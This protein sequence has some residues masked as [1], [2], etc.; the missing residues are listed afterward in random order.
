MLLLAEDYSR[1]QDQQVDSSKCSMCLPV[2]GPHGARG[3]EDSTICH[4]SDKQ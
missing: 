1:G 2:A 3:K 4:R